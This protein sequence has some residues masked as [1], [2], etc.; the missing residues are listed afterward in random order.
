MRRLIISLILLLAAFRPCASHGQAAEAEQP[1]QQH[2]YDAYI[3]VEGENASF[4]VLSVLAKTLHPLLPNWPKDTNTRFSIAPGSLAEI[5]LNGAQIIH[6]SV[7]VVESA[8]QP[9]EAEMRQ[10]SDLARQQ[11]EAEVRRVLAISFE[12][13]RR[14]FQ[15]ELHRHESERARLSAEAAKLAEELAD[16]QAASA[17]AERDDLAKAIAEALSNLR[18]LQI[19][20]ASIRARREAIEARIDELRM[21]AGAQG[22]SV[23]DEL[24]KIVKIREQAQQRLKELADAGQAAQ[25]ELAVADAQLA[26]AKIQWVRA[27][28]EG[29]ERIGGG[30]LRELNNEL[31]KLLIDAAEFEGQRKQLEQIVAELRSQVRD[32]ARAAADTARLQDQMQQLRNEQASNDAQISEL[33]RKSAEQSQPE[34]SLQPLA[35]EAAAGE[36]EASAPGASTPGD[37]EK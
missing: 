30:A 25:A 16:R 27:Q 17:G 24:E 3:I 11:L 7:Y 5:Q 20:D 2:I 29:E 4:Q 35:A 36:P 34:I 32:A 19:E 9:T 13:Q 10:L 23:V 28:R 37:S 6:S 12:A 31:S 33:R 18:G 15:N 8:I 22:D 21:R 14:R 1:P 26:E